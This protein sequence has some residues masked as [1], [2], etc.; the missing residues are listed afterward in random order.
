V[1]M[2]GGMGKMNRVRAVLKVDRRIT[3]A[4]LALAKRMDQGLG[5]NAATFTAPSPPLVVFE[6]QIAL[7]DKLEVVVAAGGRGT[8]SARNVQRDALM[9][10]MDS[11][12]LYVQSLA[13]AC[14][15]ADEAIAI[16][17][18]A[19]LTV[20]GVTS[21]SKPILTVRQGPVPGSVEL[22]AHAAALAGKRG[23]LRFFNWEYT[24]DGGKTFV[25]L[26]PTPASKTLVENL[27][28]LSS[29][30]FRVSVTNSAAVTGAWSQII[31]FLVH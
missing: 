26:P 27:T 21:Y 18:A 2:L 17:Q 22:D 15:S 23:T 6:A 24:A 19:G 4:V 20:A 3:A 30:G 25:T 13:D 7:V 16:I 14:G 8:A 29:Y 9:A 28:P 11:Q 5:D 10:M 31:V 12:R 1:V